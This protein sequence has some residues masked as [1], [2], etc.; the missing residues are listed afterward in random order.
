LAQTKDTI[1]SKKILPQSGYEIPPNIFE[2]EI[3][4]LYVEKYN[5]I[6]YE[7]NN[8]LK[9]NLCTKVDGRQI[10]PYQFIT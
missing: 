3:L 1:S 5:E 7:S 8:R 9:C 4:D 10:H 2:G 6:A